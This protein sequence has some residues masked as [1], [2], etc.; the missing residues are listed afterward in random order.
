MC[1]IVYKVILQFGDFFLTD[2][3]V[4]GYEESD[5]QEYGKQ[6]GQV[7]HISHLKNILVQ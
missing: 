3:E 6:Q 2:N 4:D 5:E 1:H 7:Y